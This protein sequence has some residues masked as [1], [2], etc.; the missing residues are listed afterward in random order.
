MVRK[1]DPAPAE[2]LEKPVQSTDV[3]NKVKVDHFW[4]VGTKG[5][6]NCREI[7]KS[8][9]G[10]CIEVNTGDRISA[11]DILAH[12]FTKQEANPEIPFPTTFRHSTDEILEGTALGGM[13]RRAEKDVYRGFRHE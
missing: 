12:S 4:A 10:P 3:G 2:E 9:L 13:D 6:G 8:L 1:K 5:P 11:S 7:D